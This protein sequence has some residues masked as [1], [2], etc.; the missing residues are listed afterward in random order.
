MLDILRTFLIIHP[1]LFFSTLIMGSISRV[2][3]IW[4]KD[5]NRQITIARYWAK[6]LCWSMGI[7]VKIEG[8]EKIDRSRNYIFAANHLSYTDTP[9]LLGNL[10]INCRFL[11]K[12]ELFN[13]PF[14]G[15]HLRTAGHIP[16]DLERPRIAVRTLGAAGRIVRDKGISLLIFPEGGRTQGNMGKFKGGAAY[17]AIKSGVPVI[18]VAIIGTREILPM[19]GKVFHPG[20]VRIKIGDPLPVAH[21]TRRDRKQFTLELE[22]RVAQMLEGRYGSEGLL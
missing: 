16:V 2:I 11:A 19:H 5:G 21:L 1:T 8:M 4:D 18:P 7:R 13:I 6:T 14:M 17:L 20:E 22:K 9:P 3:S 10:G 15:G 12:S